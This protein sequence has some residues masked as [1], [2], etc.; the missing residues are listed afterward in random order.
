MHAQ[1]LSDSTIG[2]EKPIGFTN[3]AV[4]GYTKFNALIYYNER[5]SQVVGDLEDDSNLK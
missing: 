1:S 5:G 3:V 4:V 2:R